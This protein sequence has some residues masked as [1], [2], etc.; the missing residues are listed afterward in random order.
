[1]GGVWLRS[2]SDACNSWLWLQ[3]PVSISGVRRTRDT[4]SDLFTFSQTTSILVG[5]K[6]TRYSPATR[7]VFYFERASQDFWT[8]PRRVTLRVRWIFFL[9]LHI[10]RTG[11]KTFP[12]FRPRRWLVKES[13]LCPSRLELKPPILDGS[14]LV[15]ISGRVF[16]LRLPPSSSCL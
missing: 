8:S 6:K 9:P 5:W 11:G 12:L 1:M 16:Q 13:R 10:Y 15:R 4:N 14:L 7:S 2:A 3:G